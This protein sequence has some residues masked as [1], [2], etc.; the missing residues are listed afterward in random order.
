[1]IT[2]RE[3]VKGLIPTDEQSSNLLLLLMKINKV[4]E[5]YGRQMV[6][7]SGLRS[8]EDHL[9][10]YREKGITDKSR[11]PMKSKH[12]LGQ[13]VDI[14][15]PKGGQRRC[16]GTCDPRCCGPNHIRIARCF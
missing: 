5:A 10:I 3:I 6:V 1:M 7:T 14:A 16:V 11:I 12:L 13:A 8:M 2:L 4:R 9:R 15:D